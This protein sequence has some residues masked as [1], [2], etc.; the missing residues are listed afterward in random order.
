MS[1]T[2]SCPKCGAPLEY[3]GGINFTFACPFCG[4]SVIVPENLRPP[5]SGT[6]NQQPAS[7]GKVDEKNLFEMI[8]E[9]LKAGKKDDAVFL[10]RLCY[11]KGW[12][13]AK[14]VIDG[15]EAGT[16]MELPKIEIDQRILD[17]LR[18]SFKSHT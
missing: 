11:P 16:V 7:P 10:Y 9:L 1:E 17:K 6:L 8:Q 12:S 5:L 15:I 4:T 18:I 14:N 2:F 3:K 13:M